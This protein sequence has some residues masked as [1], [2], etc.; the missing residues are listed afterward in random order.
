MDKHCK[1]SLVEMLEMNQLKFLDFSQEDT[2]FMLTLEVIGLDVIVKYT[3]FYLI[4][5]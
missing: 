4:H 3:L 5:N 2:K 1:L